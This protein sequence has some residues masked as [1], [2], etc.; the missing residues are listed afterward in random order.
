MSNY[1]RNNRSG[2]G[3]RGGG[4][5]DFRRRDSGPRQMHHAVCDECGND[6]EVP[7]KPS[8][9]KP[10]YCSSCFEKR[11]GGSSQRS[12]GR[13]SGSGRP[14]RDDNTHKKLLEQMVSINA[15]LERVLKAIEK[16]PEKKVISKKPKVKKI[17]KKV[18]SKAK[19][20]KVKKTSKTETTKTS[21]KDK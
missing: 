12:G 10:I 18:T 2:G 4:G 5:G 13:G 15:K 3:R 11:N 17:A 14:S 8:G 6:C 20:V 7:F 16:T 19:N 1:D 21:K 9:D